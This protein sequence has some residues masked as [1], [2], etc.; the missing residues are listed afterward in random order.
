MLCPQIRKFYE[1]NN[2]Q[3][4][5]EIESAFINEQTLSHDDLYI[6]TPFRFTSTLRLSGVTHQEK[7]RLIKEFNLANL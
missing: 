3:L 7:K 2:M 1:L 4:I 6:F 5:R